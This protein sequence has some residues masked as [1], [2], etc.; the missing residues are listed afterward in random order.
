MQFG[1]SSVCY[2][3]QLNK[4][5]DSIA[6][7]RK[8]FSGQNSRDE[9][10][11]PS[12]S[13]GPEAVGS[14]SSS[15]NRKGSPGLGPL[16]GLSA[17]DAA[18]LFRVGTQTAC[19]V[20]HVNVMPNVN[21]DGIGSLLSE[22]ST[23]ARIPLSPGFKRISGAFKKLHVGRDSAGSQPSSQGSQGDVPVPAPH[24]SAG[25]PRVRFSMDETREAS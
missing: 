16:P 17:G 2:P 20:P 8:R 4:A 19:W 1:N 23:F 3:P 24:P 6:V 22:Q 18:S 5:N 7:A 9:T 21:C 11:S 25:S 14:P 13:Q 12:S 10:D 15:L